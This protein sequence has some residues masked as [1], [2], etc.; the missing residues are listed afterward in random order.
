MYGAVQI[1]SF[2]QK[3]EH[4]LIGTF[5]DKT[6]SARFKR[7]KLPLTV[8]VLA[9]LAFRVIPEFELKKMT[10]KW[11][12][13]IQ[14]KLDFVPGGPGDLVNSF[15][16]SSN[17]RYHFFKTTSFTFLLIS[18]KSIGRF[19]RFFF[20]S[21]LHHYST[22]F[23]TFPFLLPQASFAMK[24]RADSP[25]QTD[26]SWQRLRG[27]EATHDPLCAKTRSRID[28]T[29]ASQTHVTTLVWLMSRYKRQPLRSML[30]K[31]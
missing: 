29:Q 20:L 12:R 1:Y 30:Y 9:F 22:G 11:G 6:W 14:G 28:K 23:K 15:P 31:K 24:V 27:I 13:K 3:R 26:D 7:F 5:S 16:N 8:F 17:I 4:D 21:T 10:G 25:R 2:Y 19:K 18:I